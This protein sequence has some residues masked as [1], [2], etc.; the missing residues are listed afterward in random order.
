MFST[1]IAE[2]VFWAITVLYPLSL[3][4]TFGYMV[5]KDPLYKS[6]YEKW[7]FWGIVSANRLLVF[8]VL[9]VLSGWYLFG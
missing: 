4:A 2:I 3:I 9:W 6:V 1:V 7:G 8:F 5:K